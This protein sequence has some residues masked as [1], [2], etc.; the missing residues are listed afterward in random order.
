MIC[1]MAEISINTISST[2][3]NVLLD[4]RQFQQLKDQ[5][6][7]G[8]DE[9]EMPGGYPG[10]GDQQEVLY[11]SLTYKD[12]TELDKQTQGSPTYRQLLK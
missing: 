5:S 12:A 11:Q 1:S 10:R 6:C 8:Q 4:H 9:F 7:I 2:R 3:T